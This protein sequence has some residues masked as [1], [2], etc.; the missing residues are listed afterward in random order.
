MMDEASEHATR[1]LVPAFRHLNSSVA[2]VKNLQ[3]TSSALAL[4]HY[5]PLGFPFLA[6][7]LSLGNR[8][9]DLS[10]KHTSAGQKWSLLIDIRDSC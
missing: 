1:K 4:F 9:I 7:S 5:S 10:S 2:R 6:A 3:L 8:C